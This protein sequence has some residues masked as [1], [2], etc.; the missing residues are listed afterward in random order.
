MNSYS[1]DYID[2][3]YVQYIRD[4]GSVSPGWRKYFEEFSLTAGASAA[5][6]AT[7]SGAVAV[8]V[9]EFMDGRQTWIGTATELYA[10]LIRP[11]PS[12]GW[13][14]MPHILTGRLN[15]LTSSLRAMGITIAHHR[16]PGDMRTRRIL[17]TATAVK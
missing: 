16:E 8:A 1:L 3:L 6:Q 17:L 15:R 5:G 10:A 7:E 11:E 12:H 2:D 4:P 14:K 13:P 9:A